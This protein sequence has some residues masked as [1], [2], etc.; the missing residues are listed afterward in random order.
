MKA[1]L[2]R[3]TQARVDVV[4]ECVGAI[5]GCPLVLVGV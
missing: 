5:D 3:V 2:Q 1:L 4:G